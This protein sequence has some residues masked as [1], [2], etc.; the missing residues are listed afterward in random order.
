MNVVHEV[1]HNFV[2][3]S[4]FAALN[5]ILM[6][7]VLRVA[8]L[9]PIIAKALLVLSIVSL[10]ILGNCRSHVMNVDCW[11]SLQLGNKFSITSILCMKIAKFLRFLI[12]SPLGI[13][14]IGLDS[15]HIRSPLISVGIHLL[16]HVCLGIGRNGIDRSIIDFHAA[17]EGSLV[18]LE[19]GA[20][21]VNLDGHDSVSLVSYVKEHREIFG[22]KTVDQGAMS[23]MASGG[24]RCLL[25]L[26]N[27][28]IESISTEDGLKK[29]AAL[30][31]WV[32]ENRM[33]F[34]FIGPLVILNLVD[35][36]SF[37]VHIL[38]VQSGA[39][40]VGST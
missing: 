35:L 32:D 3:V 28:D 30:S 7:D 11:R 27:M 9:P 39:R 1:D 36:K 38:S 15:F 33:G 16:S 12:S 10:V 40:G 23:C 14:W 31:L 18:R 24:M 6:Q 20:K 4:L 13:V 8:R 17:I 37:E 22:Q 21:I 2:L 29:G 25:Y 26:L 5:E 34:E 19:L